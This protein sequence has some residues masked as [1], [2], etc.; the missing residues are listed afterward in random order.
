MRQVMQAMADSGGSRQA[1]SRIFGDPPSVNPRRLL[2]KYYTPDRLADLLVRWA[3]A[4]ASGS[5]LD[6]SCGG[7]AFLNAAA[8]VLSERAVENPGQLLYG[9]DVDPSAAD[10]ARRSALLDGAHCI[11]GDFLGTCPADL[12]GGPF[13]A[14]VG[15]PPYVR[16]HWLK[17]ARREAARAVAAE[18]TEPLPATASTWAYFVLHALTFLAPGGRL[19]MLVPEAILQARY[20]E[21]LRVTL[22]ERFKRSSFDLRPRSPIR[23]NRGA[24]RGRCVIGV[25]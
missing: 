23:R 7:C 25:R 4:D 10:F 16:H 18:C 8:R 20:A 13:A 24:G 17:G 2:G 11:T 9:V 1:D 3:L 5:V 15:N 22:A 12:P 6:P 14:V 21:P 19:A